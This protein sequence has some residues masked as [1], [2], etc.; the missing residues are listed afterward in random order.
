MASAQVLKPLFELLNSDAGIVAQSSLIK[1]P[2][3][4]IET[5][6]VGAPQR[7]RQVVWIDAAQNDDA[8]AISLQN[9]FNH[10]GRDSSSPAG[11]QDHRPVAEAKCIGFIGGCYRTHEFENVS[12]S[13][14]VSHFTRI[15]RDT[16]PFG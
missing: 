3:Q 7:A 16:V 5:L 9:R 1:C 2:F 6:L 10:L 14:A 12:R 4:R 8:A 13:V 11:C 15:V